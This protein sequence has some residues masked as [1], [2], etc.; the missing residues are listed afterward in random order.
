[1][2]QT[3]H[4]KDNN[5]YGDY[6]S[7]T[8]KTMPFIYNHSTFTS[9]IIR[10]IW[11]DIDFSNMNGKPYCMPYQLLHFWLGTSNTNSNTV[12]ILNHI[13]RISYGISWHSFSLKIYNQATSKKRLL[14]QGTTS[15]ET[16]DFET[17]QNLL[18]MQDLN[19]THNPTIQ[20]P[21]E[22]QP[23]GHTYIG[24]EWQSNPFLPSIEEL[25]TGH[26]KT[27][28]FYPEELPPNQVWAR[29]EISD[30]GTYAA[31][32][33]PARQH[34]TGQKTND[35]PLT[36][37]TNKTYYVNTNYQSQHHSLPLNGH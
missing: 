5:G 16:I 7:P 13:M 1:M 19:D 6:I 18:I 25:S 21:E 33:F 12:R 20:Y 26:I 8:T 32:M 23:P 29:T 17:S 31:D 14:T 28:T 4:G 11:V 22:F 3:T 36:T 24:D 27:F 30:L 10:S 35:T 37:T 9:E 2:G 34:T 15:Y